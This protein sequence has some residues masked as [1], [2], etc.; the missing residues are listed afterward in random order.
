MTETK[1]GL[2]K[3]NADL[4]NKS[5]EKETELKHQLEL[6]N[7]SEVQC[8]HLESRLHA[9]ENEVLKLKTRLDV[10]KTDAS[11]DN[12]RFDEQVLSDCVEELER[13]LFGIRHFDICK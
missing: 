9:A 5:D 2:V 10:E 12:A 7:E 8:V 11:I 6:L 4:K 13:Y 3:L 1:E